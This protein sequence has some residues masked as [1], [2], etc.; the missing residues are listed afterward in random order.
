MSEEYW[1]VLITHDD[2]EIHLWHGHDKESCENYLNDLKV[3]VIRISKKDAMTSWM[4]GAYG[5]DGDL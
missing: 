4:D 2:S 5:D 3:E 1:A